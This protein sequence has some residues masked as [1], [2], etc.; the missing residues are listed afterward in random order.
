M[1]ACCKTATLR[2][3]HHAAWL[4]PGSLLLLMPKCPVCFAGY[5]A[6]FTGLGV[7][8]PVASGLRHALVAGCMVIL[9]LTLAAL[10]RRRW[11]ALR[12]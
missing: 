3:A 11:L 2:R 6:L 1:K 7:S 8:L 4:L 9:M 5:L 12:M 10:I